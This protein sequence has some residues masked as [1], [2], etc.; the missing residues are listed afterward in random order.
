M[1]GEACTM[2]A[3]VRGDGWCAGLC[4]TK[5]R[6]GGGWIVSMEV[7]SGQREVGEGVVGE[8]AEWGVSL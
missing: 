1:A 4:K 3:R 5:V 8:V 7:R 6:Q 2:V